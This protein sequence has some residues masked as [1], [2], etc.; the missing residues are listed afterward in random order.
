MKEWLSWII[1]SFPCMHNAF[2]VG[3]NSRIKLQILG[4]NNKAQGTTE[5]TKLWHQNPLTSCH[6]GL[7]FQERFFL[8]YL[9]HKPDNN[10]KTSV[11]MTGYLMTGY[12]ADPELE[13][14]WDVTTFFIRVF[15][16][17]VLLENTFVIGALLA[18]KELHVLSK[19]FLVS[20]YL[21]DYLY[22]LCWL[23]GSFLLDSSKVSTC[24]LRS[25]MY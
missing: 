25:I 11:N 5:Q 22:A 7:C 24:I 12:H 14:I 23:I 3:V 4:W 10:S 21:A 16:S 15:G 19:A 1:A 2:Y 8:H 13:T 17:I 18:F 6:W 9:H 20:L